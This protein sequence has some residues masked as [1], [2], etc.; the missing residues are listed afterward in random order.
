MK[1]EQQEPRDRLL[2]SNLI[3]LHPQDSARERWICVIENGGV[4]NRVFRERKEK[5]SGKEVNGGDV[6]T[7][8]AHRIRADERQ[9]NRR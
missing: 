1:Q 6:E 8:L 4:D 2:P 7:T 3:C 5:I 9:N